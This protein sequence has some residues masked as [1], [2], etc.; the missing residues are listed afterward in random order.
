M[1][2]HFTL[3]ELLVVIAII[4]I[5]AA[6]L[7]PALSAARERARNTSCVSKLKQIGMAQ[8]LYAGDNNS[9][10]TRPLAHSDDKSPLKRLCSYCTKCWDSRH[11]VVN[12]LIFGGYFSQTFSDKH[13]LTINDV[14]PLFGCPSDSMLFDSG[15]GNPYKN[16]SYNFMVHTAAEAKAETSGGALVDSNGNGIGRCIIGQDNPQ[17]F[18]THDM[19]G[20]MAHYL[21]NAKDGNTPIH[22]NNINAL[23]LGGHVTVVNCSTS[24]QGKL[25]GGYSR[26]AKEYENID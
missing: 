3:I 9:W 1:K 4:D 14:K 2:K 5:L 6:M 19:H 23:S 21:I 7:L 12:M 22:P 17:A 26:F 16:T 11:A 20:A 24:E 25:T 10:L 13:T 15:D 18:I 8:H